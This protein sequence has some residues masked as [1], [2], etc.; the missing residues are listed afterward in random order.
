MKEKVKNMDFVIFDSTDLEAGKLCYEARHI[1]EEV[2][3]MQ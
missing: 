2:E 3:G 1:G